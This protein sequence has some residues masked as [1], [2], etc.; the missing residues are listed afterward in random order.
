M[1]NNN[2]FKLY[3]FFV[4]SWFLHLPARFSVL[5]LIRF[6]LILVTIIILGI[7]LRKNEQAGKP[8]PF[9]IK[10]TLTV[11][12][13]YTLLATPFAQ[14]PGS[15][16]KN[17]IPNFIKAVVFFY[18][19]VEIVRTEKEL[20]YFLLVFISCQTFRVLEPL[21][22]HAAHGYWGS[23]AYM[24]G[25]YM[26]RL[27]GAPSDVINP[28][29]L[30]FVICTILPFLYF[31]ARSMPGHL[32]LLI[33]ALYPS[34]GYA[35][36]LTASRSGLLALVIILIAVFLRSRKKVAMAIV[37]AT[38]AVFTVANMTGL[39]KE[40]YLSLG[41]K[42]VRGAATASGRIE[43]IITNF[44][45]GLNKPIVG[46]GLGTSREL[47][48]N[49][50]GVPQPAHNLY[51]EIF[52]EIGI[53]GLLVFLFFLWLL[54]SNLRTLTH[55]TVVGEDDK[56]NFLQNV[57]LAVETW[58]YM[59]LLFSLASYGLSSYEWYLT[60]GLIVVLQCLTQAEGQ[61]VGA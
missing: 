35:L 47:N 4:V 9:P 24:D 12:I 45:V 27:A 43:G 46:H 57:V 14:W 20:K 59:N 40:R 5:G 26:D 53:L 28:N 60:A 51:A 37:L 21:Y 38:V 18:F 52:Q 50:S 41:K 54:F 55:I 42:D 7:F 33:L 39:Q 56:D 8:Q 29:G 49:L 61:L 36:L 15:V 25:A 1:E 23:M 16:V 13:V 3:C 32:K 58:F 11:L 48:F 44:E 2:L 19:T 10:V 31:L 6:D 22:L 30:A 17:G 34:L